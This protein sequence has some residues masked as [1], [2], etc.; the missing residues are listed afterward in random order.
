[1]AYQLPVVY[2]PVACKLSC[3]RRRCRCRS[4]RGP[5]IPRAGLI[6]VFRKAGPSRAWHSD[7]RRPSS[8]CHGFHAAASLA[9][10]PGT[11][12]KREEGKAQAELLLLLRT[13]GLTSGLA[14]L[15][16]PLSSLCSVPALP[17]RLASGRPERLNC[18]LLVW[19]L[20]PLRS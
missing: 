8:C 15:Q 1:M 7:H 10:R 6:S 9:Q 2:L 3:K 16:R 18:A 19:P 20:C 17:E 12:P 5:K 11:K 4:A 14:S 13:E